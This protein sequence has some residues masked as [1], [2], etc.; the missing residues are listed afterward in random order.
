MPPPGT[1]R[2]GVR[3]IL[4]SASPRRRDLLL[5]IGIEPDDIVPADVDESPL[6]RELPAALAKRLAEAKARHVAE[7]F[8]DAIV[9]GADTVVAL[10]RRVLPKAEDEREARRCM[11]Y[12]SGR[13]HRVLGGICVIA[14]GGRASTRLISTTVAFKS[15]GQE[16]IDAYMACGEWRGKAGAY[17]IQGRAGAFVRKIIGSYS[18][19]VGLS[20]FETA[21]ML[22]SME[23]ALIPRG[24][25]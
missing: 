19:V 22:N 17:A 20:L 9:L 16:E 6:R 21:N 13:R 25:G 4:A 2:E 10:G 12:L 3:L 11:K 18:N 23:G 1:A 8:P 5:Q 15:L 7:R 14:P 24:H